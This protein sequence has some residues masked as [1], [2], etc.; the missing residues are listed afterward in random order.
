MTHK[1]LIRSV[2]CLGLALFT[3]LPMASQASESVQLERDE[4]V[5]H[6]SLHRVEASRVLVILHA[7]SGPTDR[8][9]N[10]P[11]MSNNA[12]GMLA[13][14]LVEAGFSV[15]HYDK[16]GIGESVSSQ[17]EAELRPGHYVED[18]AAWVD[19]AGAH[20]PDQ[21]VVLMGH[22]EGGLFAKAAAQTRPDRV[23]AVV[24]LAA[25]GRPAAELL[26]EQTQ[27][28]LAHLEQAFSDILD[29]LLAGQTVDDVPPL[30]NAL[31][32]PSVQPYLIDWLAMQPTELA[33]GLAQPLLVVGGSTDLQVSRVDFE[34]LAREARDSAW[35]DGMNHVLKAS[36][37]PIESQLASYMAA[38]LPLHPGL[39]PV[40]TRFLDGLVG[41][42]S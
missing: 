6:G 26:I 41:G 30:L 32:R 37:G 25:A 3:S 13:E 21:L 34:A 31:F 42:R 10:Q 40:L 11:G 7:G 16:R 20:H 23:A 24:T 33:A 35:I 5:L 19:W 14:G 1:N 4:V 8:N 2:F 39:L 18:L 17:P 27:G 28:R 38:D 15:L 22:S 36:E 9:G 29:N 12:L